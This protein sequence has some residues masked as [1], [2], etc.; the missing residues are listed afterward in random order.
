MTTCK[1]PLL[2]AALAG[3]LLSLGS[4]PAAAIGTEKPIVAVSR[5]WPATLTVSWIHMGQ[6][7]PGDALWRYDIEEQLPTG[8]LK[9][10]RTARDVR[11]LNVPYPVPNQTHRFRVCAVYNFNWKCSNED[12]VGWTSYPAAAP[13]PPPPVASTP[14]PQRLPTPVIRGERI[15]MGGDTP[16]YNV[17]L[18]W[19]NPVNATQMGLITR[20][21][22]YRNG[23]LVSSS[24]KQEVMDAPG[25]REQMATNRYKLCI[26]NAANKVC[27][28]EIT[29]APPPIASNDFNGDS[30]GDILWHNASNG[31]SQ[32]WS[33]TG[34]YRTG[35]ATV[36]DGTRPLFIG[37]P[38]HI[39]GSRDFNGDRKS[40]V[41]WHNSS[42][43][44][45]QLW[46][47]EG[48]RLAGRATVVG[49][50]GRAIYIGPPWSIVGTSDMNG[51]RR[52]DILWHN[53]ATGETQVWFMDGHKLAGRATVLGEDGNATFVG[54]PWRIA[55]TN[56]VNGDGKPDIVWH[57]GT[58]GETQLWFM[59]GHRLAGRAT[60]VAE[61][62]GA[63]AVGLPWRI[64]GT[65]DFNQD[66][67][68]D[69]LWHN[70]STG[71]TQMW[72]MN[73]RSIVRRATVNAASDGGGAFVGLPWSIMNQ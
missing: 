63:I 67:K 7:E 16:L 73:G 5:N 44:E 3:A 61:N 59:N 23:A 46:F 56:D 64:A 38:W 14:T 32:V 69:I 9:R 13:P 18:T 29:V 39:V 60:V 4:S 52:S 8:E 43:G 72:F 24:P 47:M 42:T 12:G 10:Y 48:A 41:L 26:E 31:E 70:G 6:T 54:A 11:T 51:D 53:S 2:A 65:N 57:N 68:A 45:I 34:A 62:G 33:M 55:G 37:A 1:T 25:P 20:I 27:S 35:R 17:R 36:T 15:P 19:A 58:S 21:D 50:D 28:E 66:G 22:W 40:D 71:E 30:H 49:Q